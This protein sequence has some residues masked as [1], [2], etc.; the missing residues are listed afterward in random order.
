MN[1]VWELRSSADWLKDAYGRIVLLRG[2]NLGGSNKVPR[3]PDG[4]SHRRDGLFDHRRVSFVDRPFPL[5]EADEHFARLRRWGLTCLRLVIPWEA[6]E[7]AGP[8]HYDEAYLDYVDQLVA[9][10]AHYGLA[11]IIDPHQDVWSRFT[12]GDGAPGWTIEAVGFDMTRF[13]ATGAAVLHSTTGERY[14]AMIWPTNGWKLGAATMFTLFFGGTDFAPNTLIDGEPVQQFL[15]RHYLAAF[16][17]LARR[18]CRHPNVIGY[19]PMNEPMAGWIGIGDLSAPAGMP[20]QGVRPS[21]FQ[22]MLL[23]AGV[24]QEVGIWERGVRGPQPVSRVVLNPGSLRAWQPG[25]DCI[26]RINGVWDLDH[27][28]RPRL[29]RPHH[30]AYVRRRRIDFA[31]DYLRPFVHRF[32]Q[33]IRVVHPTALIFLQGEVTRPGLRWDAGDIDQAV[34]AP[35]WYDLLLLFGRRYVPWLGIDI[36]AVNL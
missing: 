18:M 16:Q 7:H 14:P 6:I 12:G 22:A 26:W 20:E 25:M 15:Q 30:F 1:Q 17:H 35:H 4:A 13:A 23:G 34:Y 3:Y 28:D 2:V 8:G 24:P 33:A 27:H 29:L 21:P 10:A 11:V 31:R 5:A 9:R 19:E 32:V 36:H